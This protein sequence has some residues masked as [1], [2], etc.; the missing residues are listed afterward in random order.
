MAYSTIYNV[1]NPSKFHWDCIECYR[2]Y[3]DTTVKACLR[4][5]EKTKEP[6]KYDWHN[7]GFIAFPNDYKIDTSVFLSRRNQDG[8]ERIGRFKVNSKEIYQAVILTVKSLLV[9]VMVPVRTHFHSDVIKQALLDQT[10][11]LSLVDG[12]V[13]VTGKF[14]FLNG[15]LEL[16]FEE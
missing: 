2:P 13:C 15:F 3:I 8:N 9:E 5:S 4:S 16:D 14:K 12:C 1:L 11:T 7:S 10:H 6:I